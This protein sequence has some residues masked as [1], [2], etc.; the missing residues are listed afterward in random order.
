MTVKCDARA[1]GTGAAR[2]AIYTAMEVVSRACRTR[3]LTF[4]LANS[5]FSAARFQRK[6]FHRNVANQD[7]PYLERNTWSPAS[8]QDPGVSTMALDFHPILE[9]GVSIRPGQWYVV[10]PE[11]S[12]SSQ[13]PCERVGAC[14]SYVKAEEGDRGKVIISAGAAPQGLCCDLHELLITKGMAE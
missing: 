14:A 4:A 10:S 9:A 7:G 8:K 13:T 11:D 5:S 12:D 3:P 1:G 6:S 2:L